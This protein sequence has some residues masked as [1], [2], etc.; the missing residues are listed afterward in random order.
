MSKSKIKKFYVIQHCSDSYGKPYYWC[1]DYPHMTANY[2][3][4]TQLENF[5][6]AEKM[7]ERHRQEDSSAI[8]S[9]THAGG[10]Q[11]LSHDPER[12]SK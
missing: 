1:E 5:Q 10:T 4:A 2:K 3:L 7:L 6:Q 8:Y 11:T 9:V 12:I